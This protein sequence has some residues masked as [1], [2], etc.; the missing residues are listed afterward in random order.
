[1]YH[2]FFNGRD[3]KTYISGTIANL[4]RIPTEINKTSAISFLSPVDTLWIIMEQVILF[5]IS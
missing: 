5:D 1:M 4:Q 2:F 3:M